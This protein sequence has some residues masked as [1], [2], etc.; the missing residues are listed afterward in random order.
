ML[1]AALLTAGGCA[2]LP[3]DPEHTLDRVLQTGR[4]RVGVVEN[5]PWAGAEVELARQFA[6][7]LGAV[8]EWFPG[9]EQRHMQALERY[10][11]DLLI[12]GIEATSPWAKKVGLTRPYFTERIVVG[13]PAGMPAPGSLEG[14][15][16]AVK[17]GEEA[18][19]Y[20]QK[21]GAAV[22]RVTTLAPHTAAAAPDWRLPQLGLEPTRF[23]LVKKEHVMAVPPGENGWLRRLQIFLAGQESGIPDLLRKE[24]GASQ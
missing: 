11:L 7:S 18:G 24:S 16:I 4:V 2:S 13:V 9:G 3:R 22:L 15:K 17:A 10:E 8:P 14:Q 21:K 12:G 20:L 23:E 1:P 5:P 19:A 6:A